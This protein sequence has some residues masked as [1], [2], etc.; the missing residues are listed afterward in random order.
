MILP[1]LHTRYAVPKK[2]LADTRTL[3]GPS[4]RKQ[5]EGVVVWWGRVVPGDRAIVATAYRPRQLAY[6]SVDGLSVEVPQESISEMI[7]VLPAGMSVLVR[8]HTHGGRAYHSAL[9][10]RNMLIAHEGAIS[11]VIPRFA[12]A[13][14]DLRRCSVNMLTHSHGWAELSRREV[15]RRFMTVDE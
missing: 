2:V 6:R 9:D 12:A 13:S 8:L 14:V 1:T 7:D 5:L 15:A 4:S 10:D 11:V 3:L